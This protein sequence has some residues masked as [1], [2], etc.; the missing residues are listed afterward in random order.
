M[1]EG[2]LTDLRIS[3]AVIVD[4]ISAHDKL[5]HVIA[6]GTRVPLKVGDILE[7]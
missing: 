7:D 4:T 2:K 6:D 5:A 1:L 3:D